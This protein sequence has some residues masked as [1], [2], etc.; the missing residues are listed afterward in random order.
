[1]TAPVR[2]LPSP[3][4]VTCLL[5][6]AVGCNTVG[7]ADR[8]PGAESDPTLDHAAAGQAA[9]GRAIEEAGHRRSRDVDAVHRALDAWHGAAAEGDVDGYFARLAEDA[10]FLGTDAT[11]RWTRDEFLDYT[12]AVHAKSGGMWAIEPFDRHVV[13]E[14][15]HAWI[16][17]GLRHVNYSDW[18]GTGVLRRDGQDWTIVHYSMTFTIPNGVTRQVQQIVEA[19]VPE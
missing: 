4:V 10:V 14:G 1:M 16:D 18:R 6:L 15:D 3:F 7:G 2:H 5:V 8:A 17:E 12:R 13:V 19:H 9:A 11:E